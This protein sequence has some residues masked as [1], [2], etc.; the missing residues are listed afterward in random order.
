MSNKKDVTYSPRPVNQRAKGLVVLLSA[1]ALILFV[2]ASRIPT[3]GGTIQ[4]VCLF[5]IV[6]ALFVASRFLF[7]SYTYSI[8]TNEKGIPYFLI[9]EKQ[10]KRSSLVC[11]LPLRR[12]REIKPL[13]EAKEEVRGR[14]YTYVA[15]MGGGDYQIVVADGEKGRVGIKIEADATFLAAF[16][17]ALAA[18]ESTAEEPTEE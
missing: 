16:R 8:Y 6:Y 4:L 2:L 3:Y 17:D 10:G 11:Q 13:S 12:I 18:E 9:E 7:V 15:T 1:A 14:Y 5:S